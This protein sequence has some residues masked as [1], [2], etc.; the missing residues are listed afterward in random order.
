MLHQPCSECCSGQAD[1]VERVTH[2]ADGVENAGLKHTAQVIFDA[3]VL[4]V[5]QGRPWAQEFKAAKG[6]I[7]GRTVCLA[8]ASQD[9]GF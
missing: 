4:R 3:T 7:A 8:S 6:G 5:D 1:H 9:N 2:A